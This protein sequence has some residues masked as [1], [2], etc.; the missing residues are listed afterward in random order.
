[1]T[2]HDSVSKVPL[3]L[4]HETSS[5]QVHTDCDYCHGPGDAGRW[6][7]DRCLGAHWHK[8]GHNLLLCRC[9][10]QVPP[11]VDNILESVV[12]CT[13]QA[14]GLPQPHSALLNA[15]RLDAGT[16]GAVVLAKNPSFAHWFSSLLKHKP[17]NIIKVYK[18]LS[19]EPPPLGRMVHYAVVRNRAPGEPAHTH[20]RRPTAEASAALG[21]EA[22][23]DQSSQEVSSSNEGSVDG[24]ADEQGA[25][26][27]L[28]VLQ[29]D[30]VLADTAVA[31]HGSTRLHPQE[32]AEGLRS[33]LACL[34]GLA[35]CL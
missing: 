3:F 19:R 17:D 11:T 6:G 24:A 5:T 14:L 23:I 13:A 28:I 12:C 33:F 2:I 18:G 7:L 26:C 22:G 30:V 32:K 10:L 20:M 29:V 1:M 8:F 9:H 34:P 15:H 27:E 21:Q 16:S 25:Y 4:G 35:C 31:L